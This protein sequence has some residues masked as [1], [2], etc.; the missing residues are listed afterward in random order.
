MHIPK[1]ELLRVLELLFDQYSIVARKGT[2][3][4][5]Q[6]VAFS[7]DSIFGRYISGELS[8]LSEAEVRDVIDVSPRAPQLLATAATIDYDLDNGVNAVV[9]LNQAGHTLA[10]DN[11]MDGMKGQ[12][13]VIQDGGGNR[14]ITSYTVTGGSVK[15]ASGSLPVLSSGS[16]DVDV[17]EWYYDGTNIHLK[18]FIADSS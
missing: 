3:D 8:A 6:P 10:F 1:R 2:A 14:T 16:G 11:P 17:L 5:T 4:V 18:T 9:T 12:I 7:A 15:F 13:V